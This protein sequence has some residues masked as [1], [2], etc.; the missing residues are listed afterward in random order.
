MLE[1][2]HEEAKW[3]EALLIVMGTWTAD[4]GLERTLVALA[5]D[6]RRDPPLARFG[7]AYA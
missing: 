5:L 2:L 6:S 1:R 3:I 4:T 7:I